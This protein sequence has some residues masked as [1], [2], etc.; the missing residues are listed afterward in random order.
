MHIRGKGTNLSH[1][2]IFKESYPMTALSQNQINCVKLLV[3]KADLLCDI[4][5]S[6]VYVHSLANQE[7][8]QSKALDLIYNLECIGLEIIGR[9]MAL[10]QLSENKLTCMYVRIARKAGVSKT[11]RVQSVMGSEEFILQASAEA[12]RIIASHNNASLE[13]AYVAF[14]NQD[15]S[16]MEE[17]SKL[18]V[19]SAVSL[20][21]DL[22]V[23]L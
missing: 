3:K 18:V 4:S 22:S 6:M 16:L 17:V 23:K 21:C 5:E 1:S 9:N 19:R 10:T 2:I 7:I 8:D 14:Q 20:A 12:L 11:V 13:Q 15:K